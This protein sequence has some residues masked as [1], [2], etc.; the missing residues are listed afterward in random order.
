MILDYIAS[1]RQM[2]AGG[3]FSPTAGLI[4]GCVEGVFR[5]KQI[6]PEEFFVLGEEEH[7]V[8]CLSE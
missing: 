7:W 4:A 8:S 1:D 2:V 6:D 5:S 3:R